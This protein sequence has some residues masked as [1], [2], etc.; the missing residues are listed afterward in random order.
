MWSEFRNITVEPSSK[1][2]FT[3]IVGNYMYLV[4][5]LLFSD[6]VGN[7]K[8]KEDDDDESDGD[9]VDNVDWHDNNSY[10]DDEIKG[11]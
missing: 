3:R 1:A 7:N 5:R 4:R 6:G 2:L 9:D 10:D 11:R 8:K